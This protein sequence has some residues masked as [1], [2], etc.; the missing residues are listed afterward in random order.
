MRKIAN[1][2]V[3]EMLEEISRQDIGGRGGMGGKGKGV[4]P[5]GDLHRHRL[6]A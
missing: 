6:G 2:T 1:K 4:G 3:F 5:R